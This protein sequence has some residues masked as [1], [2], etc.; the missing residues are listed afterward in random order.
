[1]R[2]PRDTVEALSLEVFKTYLDK[3]LSNLYLVL[4][5]L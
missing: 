1:M 5:L 3:A 4:A 2:L